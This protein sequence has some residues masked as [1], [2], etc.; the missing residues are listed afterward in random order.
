MSLDFVAKRYGVLPSVLL[1]TGYNTDIVCAS[2]AAGHESYVNQCQRDGIDSTKP[3]P[4]QDEMLAMIERTRR[5]SQSK[6]S[7]NT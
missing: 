7:N 6:Q 3:Q 5:D 4:T 2:L 1:A